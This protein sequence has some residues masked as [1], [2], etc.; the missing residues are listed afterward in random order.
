MM[1]V[2]ALVP[3]AAGARSG[4]ED[5]GW[6]M[7]TPA[8][9]VERVAKMLVAVAVPLLRRISLR[10]LHSLGSI[11]PLPLPPV[12]MTEST[13]S[14]G[15]VPATLNL[16]DRTLALLREGTAILASRLSPQVV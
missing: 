2:E 9:V 14:T 12:R 11:R 4:Q 16:A 7:V 15:P 1:K 6:T 5:K 13:S 10:L 3:S 8:L